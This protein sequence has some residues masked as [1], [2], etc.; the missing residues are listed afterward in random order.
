TRRAIAVCHECPVRADCLEWSLDSCQDAGVWGGM[1]EED[2][3]EVR[4]QRRRDA[5]TAGAVGGGSAP[6]DDDAGELV[7]VG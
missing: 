2:R 7:S 5:A 1:G 6:A 3:R 4:R